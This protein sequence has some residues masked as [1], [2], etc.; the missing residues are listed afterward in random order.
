MHSQGQQ[1]SQSVQGNGRPGVGAVTRGRADAELV[2]G[3]ER[4]GRGEEFAPEALPPGR[5][6]DLEHSGIVGLGAAAPGVDVERESAGRAGVE[7][8]LGRE[9][10]DRRLAPRHRRAVERWFGPPTRERE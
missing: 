1:G 4:E 8:S 5:A 7:A 10:W 9:A 2:W 3:A 6:L